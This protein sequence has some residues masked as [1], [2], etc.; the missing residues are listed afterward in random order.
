MCDEG[1][2]PERVGDPPECGMAESSVV[3]SAPTSK[4]LIGPPL[5]AA[6]LCDRARSSVGAKTMRG[7]R[8]T[9]RTALLRTVPFLWGKGC[10][11]VPSEFNDSRQRDTH[12]LGCPC[13]PTFARIGI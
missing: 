7:L 10:P 12:P 13:L 11:N 9:I 1:F 8:K 3:I 2:Q 4:T 6:I 5:A